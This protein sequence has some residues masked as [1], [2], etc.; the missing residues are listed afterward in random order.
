MKDPLNRTNG[1]A[2]VRLFDVCFKQGVVDSSEIEDDYAVRDFI[3][4]HKFKFTFGTIQEP[5]GVDWRSFRFIVYR[6]ARENGLT[7]LA[8]NYIIMIRKTNY[9]W[10]LLP[11][12]MWFYLMGAKE[13]LA[14]PV[15]PKLSIFKMHRRIHWDPNSPV[16]K[17][18]R[19]DY[20]SYMHEAC[21]FYKKLDEENM[22]AS[23]TAMESYCQ[24]IFDLTSSNA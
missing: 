18:T 9:L 10:C 20:V 17:F 6:W 14:Y 23:V 11:Y 2:I 24:A 12:C 5:D 1:V 4:K 16:K 19:M 8:E 13:W 21:F 22:L 7:N 3:S 15:Q